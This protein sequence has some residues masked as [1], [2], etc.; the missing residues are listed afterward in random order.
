LAEQD[1]LTLNV[2]MASFRI[3]L[4]GMDCPIVGTGDNA[5]WSGNWTSTLRLFGLPTVARPFRRLRAH[6]P[7]LVGD[8]LN[9]AYRHADECQ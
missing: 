3:P 7:M 4:S 1:F 6:A 8:E 9:R 5:D 2:V